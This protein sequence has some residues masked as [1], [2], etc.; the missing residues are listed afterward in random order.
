VSFD[1]IAKRSA[2]TQGTADLLLAVLEEIVVNGLELVRLLV[3]HAHV[4]ANHEPRQ[5]WAVDQD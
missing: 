5:L 3:C 4:I 1:G 2:R